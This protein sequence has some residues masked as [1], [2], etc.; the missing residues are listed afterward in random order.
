M[1]TEMILTKTQIVP[2]I[3]NELKKN[4]DA[5]TR[6]SFQRFFKQTVLCHGVKS[7]VVEKIA[8]ENF[9]H[10]SGLSKKELFSIAEDLFRSGYCEESW[11]A[12]GWLHR[13]GDYAQSDFS[14]YERWLHREIDNLGECDNFFNSQ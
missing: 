14:F 4:S 2:H 8:K 13:K 10:V 7:G 12:A 1:K 5:K 3:R 9:V 11:I 6:A